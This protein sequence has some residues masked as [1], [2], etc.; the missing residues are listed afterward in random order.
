V[1]SGRKNTRSTGP[2]PISQ[3]FCWRNKPRMG[4]RAFMYLRP[5]AT[6]ILQPST[7]VMWYLRYQKRKKVEQSKAPRLFFLPK[8]PRRTMPRPSLA[9]LSVIFC[10]AGT[11]LLYWTCGAAVARVIPVFSGHPQGHPFKSGQVH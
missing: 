9:F 2:C 10:Q 11:L 6:F 5:T 1:S 8:P 3:L 7:K 4:T